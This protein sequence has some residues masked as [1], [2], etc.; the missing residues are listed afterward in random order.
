MGPSTSEDGVRDCP[1][2]QNYA[3][4]GG[5]GSSSPRNLDQS[6]QLVYCTSK[7]APVIPV[8]GLCNVRLWRVVPLKRSTMASS[9]F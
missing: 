5:R 3:A 2:T 9:K 7:P 4:G 1:L 8:S 6:R